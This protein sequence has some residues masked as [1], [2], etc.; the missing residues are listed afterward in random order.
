MKLLVEN[1]LDNLSSNT[2][3]KGHLKIKGPFLSAEIK[4][5]NRQNLSIKFD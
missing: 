5:K 1:M 3:E 2:D 4:N